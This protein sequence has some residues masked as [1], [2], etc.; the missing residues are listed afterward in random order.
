MHTPLVPILLGLLP[1]CAWASQLP[2]SG[3]EPT[4]VGVPSDGLDDALDLTDLSLE[5]LMSIDV[6]VTSVSRKAEALEETAAA[7]YVITAEDIRRSGATSIPEALRLAPG[8]HVARLSTGDYAISA[9]GFAGEFANKMLVLIDGRSVYSSLFSGVF[10][11]QQDLALQDIARIEVIRGPGGTMWGANA[12]NGVIN[13][14]TKPARDL[15]GTTV[16]L[17]AGDEQKLVQTLRGGGP[18]GESGHLRA[19][20]KTTVRGGL[21]P[22]PTGIE[23]DASSTRGGFRTDWDLGDGA[24][25]TVQ[26]DGYRED[27]T[28]SIE[29]FEPSAPFQ[30][31]QASQR[32][33]TG[34]NLLGRWSR[35]AENGTTTTLQSYFDHTE[36]D[37]EVFSEKRDNFDL[38]FQRRFAWGDAHDLIFGLG[39]RHTQSKA[40]GSD[41]LDFSPAKRSDELYSAFIQDEHQ[42]TDNLRLIYGTKVEHNAFSGLEI[43]P[44]V[45]FSLSSGE[46]TTLWGSISRAVRTPSQIEQDISFIQGF[47]PDTPPGFTTLLELTGNDD[48]ESEVLVAYELGLR[49]RP[50]EATSLDIALFLHS[51]DNLSTTEFGTAT[52]IGG[53]LIDQTLFFDNLMDG[54][55]YGGEVVGQVSLSENWTLQGSYSLLLFDLSVDPASTDVDPKAIADEAPRNQFQLRSS[56]DLTPATELDWALWYVDNLGQ[57]IDSYVRGDVRWGWNPTRE[58]QLSV[59]V[60]G[61]FHDGEEEFAPGAFGSYYGS[62]SLFYIRLDLGF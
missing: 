1:P 40:M 32:R 24:E 33:Y 13:I 2:P 30:S 12:V 37:S 39:F 27:H 52:P 20:A 49:T 31:Q 19:Y 10:W 16:R 3:P 47:L 41:S 36:I 58:T 44:N 28:R 11:P 7:V 26:G 4:D 15:D 9:R 57:Q 6:E 50:T 35:T 53:G 8:L 62:Q 61:L 14:I 60:Q 38:D 5:E 45:R 25:L 18:L 21:A 34:G 43:Q 29:V 51:Y 23:G 54:F 48:F 55:T 46:H 17:L 22:P 59:G 56:H 42:V